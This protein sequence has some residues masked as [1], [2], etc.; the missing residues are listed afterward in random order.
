MLKKID[1]P[2]EK[3][4]V[5]L[6]ALLG[7]GLPVAAAGGMLLAKPEIRRSLTHGRVTQDVK[8][9]D[10][11]SELPETAVSSADRIKQELTA[12]GLDPAALR[13]AIDAPPGSGKTTLSRALAQQAGMKHYGLD[14]VPNKGIKT[15]LGGKAF[16]NIPHAPR[17]GE[18]VEHHLLLRS[19]D[20][21]LFD[22]VVHIK[23]TPEEIK[24]QL[25]R[26]GRGAAMATMFD[27]PKSLDVGAKAFDTL[28]GETVDIGNGIQLKLRPREGWGEASIDQELQAKGIDPTGLTRHQKLLSL[29]NEKKTSGAGWVPYAKSPFSL[30]Q[31]AGILATIPAGILAGKYLKHANLEYEKVHQVEFPM[32]TVMRVPD[33]TYPAYKKPLSAEQMW[34]QFPKY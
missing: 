24:E 7:V 22:A 26:R 28:Q 4:A 27:Y 12:R 31:T 5:N 25:M 29:V 2:R 19:H 18:I 16:E 23:K 17:A 13:I 14:W 9:Q 11:N 20:P 34:A 33:P 15:I 10:I 3:R 30:G 32:G 21:E 1:I 6:P 8:T